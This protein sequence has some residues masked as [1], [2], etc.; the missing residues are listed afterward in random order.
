[1]TM[2]PWLKRMLIQTG[3]MTESGLTRRAK[4]RIHVC[5]IPCLAGLDDDI[6]AREVWLELQP[7]NTL[8]EAEAML[9]GRYTVEYWPGADKLY[10][11]W[12]E[13]I[14]HVPAGTD[15]RTRQ[16]VEHRCNAPIP[17]SWWDTRETT[18]KTTATEETDECP[19]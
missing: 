9:E 6:C 11:R 18:S 19:F 2:E 8:G 10:P 13:N 12:P 14:T 16:M 4:I 5:G 1:M 7:I 15:T 3:R 17:A